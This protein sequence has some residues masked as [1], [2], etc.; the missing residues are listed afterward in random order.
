MV[1][2]FRNRSEITKPETLNKSKEDFSNILVFILMDGLARM[3]DA[4]Y[5]RRWV[6]WLQER[7]EERLEERVH[8]M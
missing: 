5:F 6:H 4:F 7:L 2:I 8:Q 1:T 3:L